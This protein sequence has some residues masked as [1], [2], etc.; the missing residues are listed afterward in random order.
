[1]QNRI[2]LY[3]NNRKV[4]LSES[5]KILFNYKIKDVYS[6]TVV[7]N[8]YTKT[9]TLEGTKNNNE[10]FN[11]LYKL[12]VSYST[13]LVTNFN[14]SKRNP[15]EL[16]VNGELTESGYMKLDS[17]RN[18][19]GKISYNITLFLKLGDF[20]YNLMY[21][22]DGNKMTLAS[23][24]YLSG[25][26]D[27]LD[28]NIT[29]D[30]VTGAW[31]RLNNPDNNL[32]KW[33]IVN[34][35][36]AYNGI[37]DTIDC[38]HILVNDVGYT[39]AMRKWE[40]SGET[41]CWSDITG[42]PTILDNDYKLK[43][44]F[45][46]VETPREMTEWQV[47]DLR[48]YLQRPVIRMKHI[49]NAITDKDNNGGYEVVLDP[50]FFNSKNPYY[51]NAW[52]TLPLLNQLEYKDNI[53]QI[54]IDTTVDN[55]AQYTYNEI[56]KEYKINTQ[57]VVPY[58]VSKAKFSMKFGLKPNGS[59]P[60]DSILYTSAKITNPTSS[61]GYLRKGKQYG[62]WMLK[63][64][65]Y[66]SDGKQVAESNG[67]WLTST[68][69]N[70]Q[71]YFTPSEWGYADTAIQIGNFEKS[72]DYYV[73]PATLNFQI[74]LTNVS[75]SIFRIGV[76]RCY[77]TETQLIADRSNVMYKAKTFNDS[78]YDSYAFKFGYDAGS[79]ANRTFILESG[80]EDL[81]VYSNT[82]VNKQMLLTT[83]NSPADYLLSYTKLFNLYYDTDPF[84]KKVYINTMKN[85]YTGEKVD[86]HSKIDRSKE[87]NITPLSF[88]TNN[89]EMKYKGDDESEA[90]EKYIGKYGVEFGAQRINTGYDFD[91]NIKEIYDGV[92]T[93]GITTLESGRFYTDAMSDS[94]NTVPPFLYQTVTY[95]LFNSDNE[96]SECALT[97][98]KIVTETGLNEKSVSGNVMTSPYY[99]AFQKVQFHNN[100][101]PI[102]GKDCLVFFNGFKTPYSGYYIVSDDI[103]EMINLNDKPCYLFSQSEYNTKMQKICNKVN[104]LPQFS[105]YITLDSS[106]AILYSMDFGRTKELFIPDFKFIDGS[107]CIY[108]RYWQAYLNDLYDID[109]RIVQAYVRFEGKVMQDYLKKYYYFDN[110]YWVISEIIDYNPSANETTKVKFVKVNEWDVYN[111]DNQAVLSGNIIT[112]TVNPQSIGVEGGTVYCTVT[113]EDGVSWFLSSYSNGLTPSV[114][115]GTGTQTFAVSVAPNDT[116]VN[117]ELSIAAYTDHRAIATVLQAGPYGNSVFTVTQFAQ[118]TYSDVPSTGGTC[119]YTVRSTYPW[120]VVSDREYAYPTGVHSTGGTGNTEYGETLEVHWDETDSYA[121]RSMKMTF[122]NSIGQVLYVW[123]WQDPIDY[124][125]YYT[126]L[127]EASG[128]TYN[129]SGMTSGATLETQPT[130]VTV[131]DNGD[132]SYDIVATKNTGSYRNGDVI[133][134]MENDDVITRVRVQVNQKKGFDDSFNVEPLALNFDCSGGTSAL[135][136][137]N[138]ENYHWEIVARPSWV[139]ASQISGDSAATVVVV[140]S[141]NTRDE[142]QGSIV[143]YC[144]DTKA[145][146]VVTI[147][148][149]A[150]P[151]A[152][153]AFKVEPSAIMAASGGGEYT[154][155]VTDKLGDTWQVVGK[156]AWVTLSTT[157]GNSDAVITV[158]VEPNNGEQRE[159]SIVIWNR[160]TDETYVVPVVQE[161]NPNPDLF[162]IEPMSIEFQYT[163]GTQQITVTDT[164]GNNWR[165]VG[166]PEWVT[167]SPTAGT[168][169]SVI[170]VVASQNE[171]E[172]RVGTIVIFDATK[173]N[174]YTILV[175]QAAN[176]NPIGRFKVEPAVLEYLSGGGFQYITITNP[177]NHNWR[178]TSVSDWYGFNQA[179]GGGSTTISCFAEENSGATTRTSTIEFTDAYDMRK[180]YVQVIQYSSAT[181]KSITITPNPLVADPT[182]ITTSI[183]ITYANRNGDFLIPT[184]S[185]SGITI[186]SIVFT[187]DTAI[188]DITIPENNS[189]NPKT[190]TIRFDGENISST[191]TISQG[192]GD[193]LI[194]NPELIHINSRRK[195][196]RITITSNDSWTIN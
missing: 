170:S 77:K 139:T 140:C 166:F 73:W 120:T 25:G 50:A 159:N 22:G 175:T 21:D 101:E 132:G 40:T 190:Y 66:G 128:G 111:D 28:F 186:G 171:G 42:F 30:V 141:A 152:G 154:L 105:R 63:I 13:D 32:T 196:R 76:Q 117:R 90:G 16:Y 6:P 99:D 162:Y 43:D 82:P 143:V 9:V 10:I 188:V 181:T 67:I 174:T 153:D 94:A 19:D 71:D 157:G 35:M 69:D 148:Q 53:T 78:D 44:G 180:Y 114:T 88:D 24:N 74:D 113:V 133:F 8:S 100:N 20:L 107:T 52:I 149:E 56:Y 109:T 134:V 68:I 97:R 121:P 3:I 179:Q 51:E 86:I 4:D 64:V 48:S 115:A 18:V 75:A 38:Q 169:T 79:F 31:D 37:D 178:I 57:Q 147:T 58:G 1:M 124:D 47:R 92:F 102:V 15:F 145:T 83:E 29:K 12:D 138:E 11:N 191:L 172:E 62:A 168:S 161:R 177:D 173:E 127:Y 192:A 55:R 17:V 84:E 165:V 156:P 70:D 96:T 93:N 103:Q 81:G 65:A 193:Y 167:L 61:A 194:V 183:T 125:K 72:G 189:E 122:T 5:T 129:V 95:K 116:L 112:I 142:R 182:G 85:Y 46:L 104:N 126:Y 187:G 155:T 144:T 176:P 184:P 158:T 80:G 45:G 150:D 106:D 34:F 36:P 151:D 54:E 130:W 160:T 163:G 119:L 23:L 49:I 60:T 2:E 131:T 91:G 110:S 26:S 7:K 123:K 41:A 89:Y 39:G 33:D 14:S 137:T 87:I 136:I 27:E 195:I 98:P 185:D 118:Y 164:G 135:T 108:E 146:Y 59:T